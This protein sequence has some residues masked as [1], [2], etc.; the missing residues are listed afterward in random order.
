MGRL[1]LFLLVSIIISCFYFSF[2]FTFLPEGINTKAILAVVGVPLMAYHAIQNRL[3]KVDR[4]L[5]GAIGFAVVFSLICF[6]SIDYNHT[7]DF[8]YA[9]YI[10]SFSIWLLAAYT[11]CTV[12]RSVHGRVDIQLLTSYLAA[13][14]A[15][16][17]I[18][19][20]VIDANLTVQ[21]FINRYIEQGQ[22]FL[23]E[24]DRL[25]GIGASLD[26]AGVRFSIVLIL[27]ATSLSKSL[28]MENNNTFTVLFLLTAFLFVTVIGSMISRTTLIG[29]AMGLIYMI[30]N[31]GVFRLIISK[32]VIGFYGILAFMLFIAY[33][34]T[35]YLYQHNPIFHDQIRFA[36]EGFFNWI[37]EG[38]WRTDS[39]DKLNRTMWVWPTDTKTWLIG[40]GLFEDWVF[41]TDIGYCRFILYSGIT[42]F[43]VFALF[44]AYNALA[45]A[46]KFPGDRLLF[47]LLFILS[48]VVWIKVSTDIFLIYALLYSADLLSKTTN[49]NGNENSLL[50]KRFI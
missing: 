7:D 41:G 49:I 8:S 13:I 24:V 42:G 31:S 33:M 5:L 21:F 6:I 28:R 22:E 14:S 34:V 40:S 3:I 16:Q 29:A 17:C 2:G 45:C 1:C 39:T 48:L 18:I 46:K 35:A 30:L 9:T 38:E 4:A 23:T 44:F 32:R 19:A 37:E 43:F 20:L 15:A 27:I 26:N 47:L 50:H 11:V 36:F 10:V 25:Y 12:M